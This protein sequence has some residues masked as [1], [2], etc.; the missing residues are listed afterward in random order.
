M[1]LT[2]RIYLYFFMVSQNLNAVK[3][4][5]LLAKLQASEFSINAVTL[6]YG[7]LKNRKEKVLFNNKFSEEKTLFLR[8]RKNLQMTH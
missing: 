7:D 1:A 5:L 4:D 6:M 3:Y 2:L 8:F